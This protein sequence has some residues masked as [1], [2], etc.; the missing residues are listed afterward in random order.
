MYF[1]KKRIER[2]IAVGSADAGEVLEI[3]KTLVDLPTATP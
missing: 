1:Y 3:K 2:I